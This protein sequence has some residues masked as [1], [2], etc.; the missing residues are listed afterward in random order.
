MEGALPACR[1]P[2]RKKSTTVY[3]RAPY[4]STENGK[5]GHLLTQA[6]ILQV[7][8]IYGSAMRIQS[9]AQVFPLTK[10]SCCI[11]GNDATCVLGLAAGVR[12]YTDDH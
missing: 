6:K 7:A 1:E 12:Q 4:G 3:Q 5:P 10:S 8:V 11:A 2:P 9:R